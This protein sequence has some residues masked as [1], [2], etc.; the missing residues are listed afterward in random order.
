[1]SGIHMLVPERDRFLQ[2][3]SLSTDFMRPFSIHLG[4]PFIY[5][6]QPLLRNRECKI[7]GLRTHPTPVF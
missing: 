3:K 1:M 5:V 7:S 6:C 4:H 2:I